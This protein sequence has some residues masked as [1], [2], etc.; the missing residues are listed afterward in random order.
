MSR[1]M[2]TVMLAFLILP[3][4]A[5]G[6]GAKIVEFVAVLSGK[7][8]GVFT[9]SPLLNYLLASMGFLCLLCWA[10]VRGMFHDVEQPKY[11]M[12]ETECQLDGTKYDERSE[13]NDPLFR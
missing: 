3:V 12:L 13:S 8:D 6:F 4:A 1:G 5:V 2:V 7:P 11:A 9:L 10:I